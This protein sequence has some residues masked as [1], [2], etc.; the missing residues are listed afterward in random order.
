MKLDFFFRINEKVG[1]K[2]LA[3]VL[4][5]LRLEMQDPEKLAGAAYED[6]VYHDM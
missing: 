5:F 4:D 6:E 1:C 2:S 3:S